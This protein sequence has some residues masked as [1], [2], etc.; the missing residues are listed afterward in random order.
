MIKLNWFRFAALSCALALLPGAARAAEPKPLR[1]MLIL[2][3]CC[4]DYGAQKDV[5][6][7]GLEA[8]AHVVVDIVYNEDKSTKARFEMYEKPDW[9]KGYDVVIHDECSA[10]VKDMPYVQNILNAHKTVPAVNL[11]CAMHCY[12][13]GTD[14]WFKFVGIHSTGHGPQEPIALK[15][16]DKEHPILKP[17]EE[18]TT[19]REELYNNIKNFDTAKPLIRGLQLVPQKDGT[20]KPVEYV[21]AWANQYGNTRVFSTTLGHN[22]VTVADDR[23][24]NLVTR[25]L[26]WACGKLDDKSYLKAHAAPVRRVNIAQG[27]P[28]KASSEESNKGNVAAKAFDND[29]AT[30]WCASGPRHNEWLQVDLGAPTKLTGV[31]LDWE[32][33]HQYFHKIEG[34]ADGN[35]WKTLVDA[36]KNDQAGPNEHD[37]NAD[38]I[39]YLKVTFLGQKGKES[40]WGSIREFE[41]YSDK[42]EKLDPKQART[43]EEQKYLSDVKVPEGFDVTL[44]AAPPMVNYPVFVA[45]APDGTVFVSSDGNGSLGRDPHRGRIVRLRD[46]DGDG[47]AD[48]AKDFV[49]DVDSPRGLVWDH[50]RLYLLHPPHISA[51]IDKDGD[52]VADEQKILVKNIAFTF[53]DRPADHTS[54]G[55]ELGIDGW[56]YAAI[57]DFGF[58]EAEGTDGRKLQ[59]RGGGVVRVRPDGTGLELFAR[60]TRNILEAAVSPLLDAFARDNTND[61]GGWDVRF[62]HF[63]GLEEHGYPSLYKNFSDE[64]VQP[65][66]DYGGGSGCGAAWI[67]EPGIPAK[68]NNAP[69]TADWGRDWIYKHTVTP[70]G[71]TFV[72]TEKPAEFIRATRVTDLDVDASSRIYAASWRGATFNWAGPD[73]GYLVRVTQKGYT[74]PALPNFAKAT[75]AELVKLLESPSHRTRLEAQRTIVRRGKYEGFLGAL[76]IVAADRTKPLTTRIAAVFA[77]KQVLGEDANGVLAARAADPSIAAW[78]IRA[79]AD[80]L[81]QLAKASVSPTRNGLKSSDPR[82]RKESTIAYSRIGKLDHV[83]EITPLLAD[84]DPIVAHTA[85][86][87]LK[88]LRATDAC[89]AVVDTLGASA[90][91]RIGALRVLQSLHDAQVVDGLIARLGKETDVARRQ[92]L[93]TALCRLH[94]KEGVWKGDSW[95]T[96]PD[97]S[98]PYYQAEEWSESKKILA[99][100]KEVLTKARGG[101]AAHLI[102]EFNRHK[103]QSDDALNTIIEMAAKDAALLPAAIGQLSRAE[104]IPAKA[105]PLLINVVGAES[106]T[107]VTR[108]NAVIAIAKTDS[109]DALKAALFAL[110]QLEKVRKDQSNGT[111]RERRLARDAFFNAPKLDTRHVLFEHE[112]AALNGETSPWADAALLKISDRKNASPEARDAATRALDSGWA[113]ARRRAQILHAVRLVEHRPYKDKVLAA[114][115]DANP[116]VAKAA[117]SAAGALRL[118]PAKDKPAKGAKPAMIADMKLPDII[119]AVLKTHG[120]VK[121]GEQL[122]TQ[123]SCVNCH[124]VRTDEPQRGPFLGTIATTY[125]RPELT[126]AILVP[127]KSIAQGFVANYFELKDGTEHEGFVTLEAADKVVIRNVVAQEITIPVKDIKVRKKLEKSLMPEGLAANLSVKE[128]ASLID[129]LEDLAKK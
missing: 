37:F 75:D 49:K 32:F 15:F 10:D 59:L 124:T 60:G 42:T 79:I 25:G 1:A 91:E 94:F 23:Y 67:D 105:I 111:E 40:S 80:N 57:G 18:W 63:S 27:K 17:L 109:A 110:P 125:K 88:Q 14:D 90:G 43:A 120:D 68:W 58:M 126:E 114:L 108:A 117:K 129:Y 96:R 72:E 83:A 115:D 9:A 98:G 11:H 7:K 47:R 65:L 8:R 97:T 92:G 70:K 24:L 12:R 81:S 78:A 44:F 64:M 107:D 3:G 28:A 93:L 29:P 45:A 103:I 113:D 89:F 123:Q 41:V 34:S 62:H 54:N 101:E 99:V 2:G 69:F 56:L 50:D 16:I 128:L 127:N 82:I 5:L 51:F 100:L 48:E 104:R 112:A 86:Q 35:A 71:A 77:L 76:N 106:S 33:N 66:A 118:D 102:A 119:S 19:I 20:V 13:V 22:T 39:R 21:V 38:G 116:D 121:L 85:V 26:L 95:G 6:K 84:P 122:F 53:K 55:L 61:G 31:R 36:A 52:G 73:V 46:L 74:P 30:R 4:H 87:A